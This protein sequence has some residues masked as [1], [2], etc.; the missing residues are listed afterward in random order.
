MIKMELVNAK[1]TIEQVED[2]RYIVTVGKV[3]KEY[4]TLRGA[5]NFVTKLGFEIVG[6]TT[7]EPV[8]EDNKIEEVTV[9]DAVKIETVYT[10]DDTAEVKKGDILSIKNRANDG[11]GRNSIDVELVDDTIKTIRFNRRLNSEALESVDVTYHK[12]N[13]KTGENVIRTFTGRTVQGKY[14]NMY[15]QL[16]RGAT[17]FR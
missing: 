7:V 11:L 6:E 16:L 13:T 14:H 8:V 12:V 9:E 17:R 10:K 1:A 4:K 2:K 15:K 3:T 5:K